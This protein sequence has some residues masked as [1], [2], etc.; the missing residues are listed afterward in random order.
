MRP[1]TLAEL[2]AEMYFLAALYVAFRIAALHEHF[3]HDTDN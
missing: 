1:K 3:R 2:T